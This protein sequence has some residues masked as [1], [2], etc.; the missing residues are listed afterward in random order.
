MNRH[1]NKIKK[2]LS[3]EVPYWDDRDVWKGI[4]N[5]LEPENNKKKGVL[6]LILVLLLVFISGYLIYKKGDSNTLSIANVES[7]IIEGNKS[8]RTVGVVASKNKLKSN[9]TKHGNITQNNTLNSEKTNKRSSINDGDKIFT[10]KNNKKSLSNSINDKNIVLINNKYEPSNNIIDSKNS[11]HSKVLGNR[12]EITKFVF[13]RNSIKELSP[14]NRNTITFKPTL[15]SS[16]YFSNTIR[17]KKY[18]LD[19][20]GGVYYTIR[21]LSSNNNYYWVNRKINKETM[22]ESTNYSLA[23][24]KF[25]NNNLSISLGLGYN[26]IIEKFIHTDSTVFV[27]K[28]YSDTAYIYLDGRYEGG[29][30]NKTTT[31]YRFIKSPNRFRFLSIPISVYYNIPTANGRFQIGTGIN[32]DIWSKYT[33]YSLSINNKTI[34]SQQKLNEL[35]KRPI[36]ISS[37]FFRVNY[38]FNIVKNIKGNIGLRSVID[39]KS[40]NTIGTITQKYRQ[41]GAIIGVSYVFNNYW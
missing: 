5:S 21:E 10:K 38:C 22:L 24:Q 36:G 3:K 18:S 41:H 19:F 27:T 16:D 17:I 39:L 40:S 26:Q 30:V 25:F 7:K 15:D 23:F 20:I 32:I 33:G 34:H 28:V 1:R 35:Y 37:L 12:K 6:F 2:A 31:K 9:L 4:E 8:S 29:M 14:S 11:F 13:I